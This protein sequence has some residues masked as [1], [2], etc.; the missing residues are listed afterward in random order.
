MDLK[1]PCLIYYQSND[2]Y[3]F[4]Y[5]SQNFVRTAKRLPLDTNKYFMIS[6]YKG[7]KD[8]EITDDDLLE[9]KND[10]NIWVDELKN[11]PYLK[12]HFKKYYNNYTATENT[13][14]RL[15]KGKFENFE[16]VD[17][18]ENEWMNRCHN[19]ALV[20][21]KSKGTYQC[22]GYDFKG[23]Y[24]ENLT[25]IK[26]PSKR[27]KEVV[28]TSLFKKNKPLKVGYYHVSVSCTHEHFSKLF[29][30]SKDNVYTHESL[31]FLRFLHR[32]H[33]FRIAVKLIQDGK[34][35]AYL[36]DDDCIIEGNKIFGKWHDVLTQIKDKFPHNRLVKHLQSSLWGHIC[37]ANITTMKSSEIDE[38]NLWNDISM[39]FSGKYHIVDNVAKG[40]DEYY[41]LLDCAKPY[42]Y[43]LARLKPF[44]T[45]YSRNRTAKVCLE[46]INNVIRVHTDNVTFGRK[47]SFTIP[48][49]FP[50]DKTTGEITFKNV[51][52]REKLDPIEFI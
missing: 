27:G 28:L 43:G 3:H 1:R 48:N 42:K 2:I 19:G 33:K 17:G 37:M 35:N 10:F 24:P 52:H 25:K 11:N 51:N 26:I 4:V 8:K 21:L 5:V 30:L 20:Y 15:A 31:E 44:L 32:E 14:K 9:Y 50:E 29:M 41:K 13:F 23:Y 45:S 6:G 34:P 22:Y 39:D 47:Q 7:K 16:D 40:D 46:D 38:K 12:I 49:L 18:I 36:Y